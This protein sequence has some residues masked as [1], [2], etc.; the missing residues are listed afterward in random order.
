MV[1]PVF[2]LSF[3]ENVQS[4]CFGNPQKQHSASDYKR[5]FRNAKCLSHLSQ[6][7]LTTK[8]DYCNSLLLWNFI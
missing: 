5:G 7:T 6:K 8:V 4:L 2:L 3:M 1:P